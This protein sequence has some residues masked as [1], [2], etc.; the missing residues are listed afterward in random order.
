MF[1]VIFSHCDGVAMVW[2]T[3]TLFGHV[4]ADMP[5]DL[6]IVYMFEPGPSFQNSWLK[7]EKYLEWLMW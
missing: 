7:L 3:P 4:V 1:R 2:E 5:D 6:F